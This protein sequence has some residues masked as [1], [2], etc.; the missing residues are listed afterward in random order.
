M[1][2]LCV[3]NPINSDI[4]TYI[5][6]NLF[7]ELKEYIDYTTLFEKYYIGV[8]NLVRNPLNLFKDEMSDDEW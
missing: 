4:L 6:P 3:P 5:N 8:L 1:I 7:K 2:P